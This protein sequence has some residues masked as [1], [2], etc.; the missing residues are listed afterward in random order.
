MRCTLVLGCAGLT[1]AARDWQEMV[2]Q[3]GY[4]TLFAAA[5][6]LTSALALMNNI[7]EIRTDA[8]KLLA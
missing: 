8:Y 2:V 3:Y 7:I 4:V 5:F 1:R 6:P